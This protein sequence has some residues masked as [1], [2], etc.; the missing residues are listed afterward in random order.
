VRKK[1]PATRLGRPAKSAPRAR[2]I[3]P[4]L[5]Y[6][7][8][9]LLVMT[10]VAALLALLM[11][12]D[13]SRL[14]DGQTATTIAAYQDRIAQLRLDVDR[15]H[16]RQFAQTGDINLQ[17]QELAQE[18]EVLAEQHQYVKALADKASEL[19]IGPVG[20]PVPAAPSK[21]VPLAPL[22]Q[23]SLTTGTTGEAAIEQAGHQVRQM[24]DDSRTAL[25][26]ISAEANTS[27]DEILS[28]L[29]E[30]GIKPNLPTTDD[31]DG[32]GGPLLP[33]QADDADSESLVDQA[34][35]V[36]AALTRFKAARVAIEDAPIH[37][38]VP[39][40]THISSPFGNRTDPFTGRVAFHPG[41]DFPWPTG[42]TVKSAGQGKVVYVGQIN[43]YGNVVDIDHGGGIVTRYGHLSAFLVAKGDEVVTG[44]P[45][46]RVG[47]TGRSTG[48]HL[49]FEVRRDDSPVNPAPYLDLG[50]RLAHFM[51]TAPLAA[52]DDVAVPPPT[53]AGAQDGD[54]SLG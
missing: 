36:A 25:A 10:N 53:N 12:P 28:S 45:I 17:L 33:P 15:L 38:P 2:G 48:P 40:N 27:T 35:D 20:D 52:P 23:A 7:V 51:V 18:Q 47:S 19:G 46:A 54:G 4:G 3:R 31:G 21:P 26:T 22:P 41:I 9:A 50:R 32:M 14:I 11:S 13:I 6:G 39:A 8:F 1:L 49:H 44:T 29:K 16:S 42:T 5:F 34:N 43:G 24:M 37:M 30:M